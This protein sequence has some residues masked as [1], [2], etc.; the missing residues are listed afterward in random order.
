[1]H[2]YLKYSFLLLFVFFLG[3]KKENPLVEE[4]APP[5]GEQTEEPTP[6]AES[7][8]IPNDFLSDKNYEKLIVEVL[9]VKGFQ[10]KAA[11]VNNLQAFLEQRL[12]KPGGI[13]IVE[14]EIS[15]PGKTAYSIADLRDIEKTH[16]S[17][18]STTETLTAYFFFADKDYAG[19]S[20]D[21]KVLGVAY[22]SSSMAIFEKTVQ[23]FS[24]G[25]TQP[26]VSTLESTVIHHEFAHILGLVNN[27]TAMQAAHQDEAHGRHCNNKKCLMYYA[28]ETSD[29]A[30]LLTGGNV[31]QLDASCIADLQGNGGR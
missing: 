3:C 5:S 11:S 23:D 9:Y 13:T 8:I 20:G 21:A 16:R 2:T 10:P 4:Q 7:R 30:G 22:G 1:M 28:A 12:I 24:G 14:R 6:V 15:S 25:L 19:N 26:A 29:I 18:T 31:P 27:G 17:Q